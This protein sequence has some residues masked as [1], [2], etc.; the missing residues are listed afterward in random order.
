MKKYVCLLLSFSFYN[1]GAQVDVKTDKAVNPEAK[2]EKVYSTFRSTRVINAHSVDM[3]RKGNLDFRI[4]HRFGF[5]DQGIK[6]LFGLDQASMR[7]G[8]DYGI[9]DN[10]TVGVGRST[11]RKEIDLFLK[12]R[13]LQQSSGDK[14][15]PLSVAIATGGLVY[16]EQS[17][18]VN[19]PSFSDR[20]SFYFQ[21]LAGRKFSKNFS[22]QLGPMWVHSNMPVIGTNKDLFSI[23][24]GARYKFSRKLAATVDFHHVFNTL[25]PQNRDPLSI[26]L[27]IE[28]NGHIFQLHFSNATGMNE[29]AYISETF[30]DFFKGEI[31][32]G[33]NLSRMFH[34][35]SRKPKTY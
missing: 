9:T 28:T 4:L 11:Y 35:G 21:L 27:D 5:V 2:T 16:T 3:L 7:L 31:R 32:F 8:F 24:G 6:Q 23:G 14:I 30:G 1:A 20:S 12:Y 10:F 18:A 34:I 15:M 13:I 17:F 33:F 29:R 25:I 22:F 26:G 19:K